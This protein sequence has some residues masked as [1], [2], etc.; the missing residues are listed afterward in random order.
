[1]FQNGDFVELDGLLAVVVGLGGETGVPE[2]HV[3]LWFGE[4]QGRRISDGG[5]GGLVPVVWT[6][7]A[8]H[9]RP[10]K[11]PEFQH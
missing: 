5:A 1:M 6:V 11:T 7:P 4:P 10:A 9:C 8:E 2:G 3:A